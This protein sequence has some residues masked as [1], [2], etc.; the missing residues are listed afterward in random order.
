MKHDIGAFAIAQPVAHVAIVASEYRLPVV[1]GA[2]DA[3]RVIPDW[4]EDRGGLYGGNCTAMTRVMGA[5]GLSCLKER[6]ALGVM[7]KCFAAQS[8]TA[9]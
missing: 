2:T 4:G 9:R 8:R 6:Q 3:T 5:W 1:D 7:P